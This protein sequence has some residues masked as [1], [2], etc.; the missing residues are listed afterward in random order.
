MAR[1][2]GSLKGRKGEATR[3]G[4]SNSGLKAQ[5]NGWDLG[6]EVQVEAEDDKDVFEIWITSGSRRQ[7]AAMFLARA[8]MQDG[9]LVV[10]DED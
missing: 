8:Y 3:L 5:I 10:E 6:I 2:W 9:K 7:R 1:F 4:D